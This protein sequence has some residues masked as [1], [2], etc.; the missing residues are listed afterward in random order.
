M[1]MLDPKSFVVVAASTALRLR[2]LVNRFLASSL[3]PAGYGLA[4]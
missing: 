1:M 3:L 2:I 4:P